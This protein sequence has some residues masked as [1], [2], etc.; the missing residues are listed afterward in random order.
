MGCRGTGFGIATLVVGCG[1]REHFFRG[2]SLTQ[3]L[4]G[5]ITMWKKKRLD[6][7]ITINKY[8]N[9]GDDK[10]VKKFFTKH[11]FSNGGKILTKRK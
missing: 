10:I 3:A 4:L 6:F 5:F 7:L 9:Q 2:H 11:T 1:Q 8:G